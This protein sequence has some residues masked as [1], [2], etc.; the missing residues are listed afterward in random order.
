M[1]RS[2]LCTLALILTANILWAQKIKPK[3][4]YAE[5]TGP[6]EFYQDAAGLF[7]TQNIA[8]LT[9]QLGKASTDS[10]IKYSNSKNMPSCIATVFEAISNTTI[11]TEVEAI[12]KDIK[13]YSAAV[14]SNTKEGS[15]PGGIA[16]LVVPAAENKSFGFEDC[17]LNHDIYFAIESKYVK[18]YNNI[19]MDE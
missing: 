8:T 6:A 11:E 5:V 18:V 15:K 2:I 16:I 10:I 14:I 17:K 9:K 1:K 12:L 7:N 4:Y 3:F 13:F 19:V